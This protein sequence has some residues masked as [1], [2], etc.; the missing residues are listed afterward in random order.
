MKEVKKIFNATSN[1]KDNYASI[2]VNI[3]ELHQ[4]HF[5]YEGIS[6]FLK[7]KE[8]SLFSFL[9]C[10]DGSEN[11]MKKE[12]LGTTTLSEKQLEDFAYQLKKRWE[13]EYQ[14]FIFNK[15]K[16]IN[17]FDIV[18]DEYI[19][20]QEKV[21]QDFAEKLKSNDL[22]N[23]ELSSFENNIHR[24]KKQIKALIH[25]NKYIK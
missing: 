18:E 1:S 7:N 24:D 25:L 6:V 17:L 5:W 9:L 13:A 23:L 8:E 12:V 4:I 11:L 21:N 16:I 15:E 20:F 19:K 14:E 22:V 3:E 2:I 10:I